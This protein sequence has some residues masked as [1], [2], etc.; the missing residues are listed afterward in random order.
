ME[1]KSAAIHRKMLML[2]SQLPITGSAHK[3]AVVGDAAMA[4]V[5][6]AFDMAAECGGAAA[7]DRRHHLELG[8]A[9]MAG[10]RRTPRWS[11]NSKDIG[12]LERWSHRDQPPGSS[13]SISSLRC[14]S[15][16]VTARIVLVATRA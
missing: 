6:A 12:D 16:L 8:Q 7:L 15:G 5:L 14:S 2:V 9:D 10:I 1:T 11:M 3:A 4:A 13:P